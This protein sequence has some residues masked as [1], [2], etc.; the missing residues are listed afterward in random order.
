M[1]NPDSAQPI[2]LRKADRS[3]SAGDVVLVDSGGGGGYGDPL[4][5]DPEAVETDLRR[6]YISIEAAQKIY[7]SP[8]KKETLS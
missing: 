7:G 5:R 1:I 8:P 2:P 4:S 3:L 6:G